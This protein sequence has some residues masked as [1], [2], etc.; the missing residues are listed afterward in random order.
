MNVAHIHYT[1]QRV[2]KIR[3]DPTLLF[4]SMA[5]LMNGSP[6]TSRA[7]VQRRSSALYS[8]KQLRQA[9]AGAAGGT[10]AE[11]NFAIWSKNDRLRSDTEV[12]TS[13]ISAMEDCRFT[14]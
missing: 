8:R 6:T 11:K 14:V 12:D 2:T 10:A 9:G 1:L 4:E 7:R 3:N 13:T 5:S